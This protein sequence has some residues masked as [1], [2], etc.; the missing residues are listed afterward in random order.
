MSFHV[1]DASITLAEL[2][3]RIEVTDLVPSRAC[4]RDDIGSALSALGAHGISTLDQ[5]R[6]ALKTTKRLV[7]V[8]RSTS[9]DK[10]YLTLL[11][12]EIEGY[13]PKPAPLRAFDWLPG[14]EIAVLQSHG[15]CDVAALSAQVGDSRSRAALAASTGVDSGVLDS[16]ARLAD[17]SRVPWVSPTMARWLAEAGYDSAAKL[18]ASDAVQLSAAL[19]QVN[20]DNRFFKGRIGLRDVRRL[21]QSACYV[22]D[23]TASAQQAHRAERRE[24]EST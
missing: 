15:V 3:R 1:D 24:V 8:A 16:L 22:E 23:W 19:E 20:Q 6:D 12:R 5:L 14:G 4:L 18:A 7:E 9:V 21:V 2:R 17:L 13:F 10:Q 11:R